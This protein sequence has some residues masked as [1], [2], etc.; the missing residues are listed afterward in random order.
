MFHKYG[1]LTSI[2]E[3]AIQSSESVT[4]LLSDNE[5]NARFEKFAAQLKRIAPKSNEF[6]YFVSPLIV[7]A[8]YALINPDGSPKKTRNGEIV[9]ASWEKKGEG[10]RWVC[11]DPSIRPHKN[12]NGDIFPESEIIAAHKQWISKPI[13]L[14]HKNEI[15]SV[16][17]IVLDVY[18]DRVLKR[19]IALCAIDKIAYPELARKIQTRVSDGMS[20]GTAVEKAI[21]A[22]EGCHKV[23]RTADQF[24]QHMRYKTGYGEI[25][26]GLN[27]IEFSCVTKPAESI[28]RIRTVF[29]AAQQ[30]HNELDSKASELNGISNISKIADLEND[31][32]QIASKFLELKES[33]E[34]ESTDDSNVISDTAPYGAS[35]GQ[36][37]PPSDEINQQETQLNLP[38]RYAYNN[39][40]L[41]EE[42]KTLRASFEHKLSNIEKTL[43][44]KNEELTMATDKNNTKTAY[45]LG[46]GEGNEPTPGKPRYP[47]DPLNE[48]ARMEDKQMVGQKPFPEVGS[49]DGLHPSP[50]SV[51]EKD[52]LKRKEMIQRAEV[53]ER[54]MRRNA[55]LAQ[56][57]STLEHKKSYWLGTEEPTPGKA[58]YPVDPLNVQVREKEDKQMVGQSPFPDVGPVDGLHP[59]PASVAEKDELKRKEMLNR[60]SLK[61]RFVRTANADGTENLGTSGWHVYSK[62][63]SGEKLVFTASVDEISGGRADALFDVIATKEFGSKMLEKIRAVGIQKAASVYKQAQALTGPGAAPGA[64]PDATGAGAMPAMPEAMPPANDNAE[65]AAEDEGGKG[66]PK[67]TAMKLAEKNRDVASDLLEAIRTLT[68]EQTQMGEMEEG[69]NALPKA[70]ASALLPL[71]KTRVELNSQL[72]S[73]MKKSLAELNEHNEELN[74]ITQILDS[75]TVADKDYTNTVVEDA[76]GDAKSAIADGFALMR[77]YMKYARGTAGLLK[78]AEDAQ[79]AMSTDENDARDSSDTDEDTETETETK[80]DDNDAE[81]ANNHFSMEDDEMDIAPDADHEHD[82]HDPLAMHE[83]MDM[84]HDEHNEFETPEGEDMDATPDFGHDASDMN[85]VMVD[86]DP[87][88]LPP[89]Q[90]LKVAPASAQGFDLTTKAGRSAYRAKI[91][92]DATGKQDDGKLES[93]ESLKMS[94]TVED[95]DKLA[96]GGFLQS[97]L[98]VKPSDDLGRFETLPEQQKRMLEVARMPPKIRQAAERLDTLISQGKVAVADLDT[99]IAQGLDS[100]VVKYW[101]QYWGEAGKEGAEFGKLLT[102]ETMKAKAEEENKAFRVKLARA[103]ELSYDM[104]RRGLLADDRAAIGSHVD[105]VM[106]WNDEG[107]ESM[108]RVIARHAPLSIR[109]EAS[110]PQVGL[111]GS[112]DVQSQARELDFQGELDRAFAN[113][114]Y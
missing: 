46:G 94:P 19:A 113:R 66:D 7:S 45:W 114:K 38:E 76:L 77:A 42:L 91:A 58:Q 70:A 41:V 40:A 103:Y 35:S 93:A 33:M 98:D 14:D 78:R 105:E 100:E 31:L 27:P 63:E 101:R 10:I 53:E 6:L 67:E 90:K 102:T 87:S 39:L 5:I 59:S 17:G 96:D 92:N 3:N 56:A 12:S 43:Q 44:I 75:G 25:N 23:A 107:F 109:K 57:K 26:V 34:Q 73:G 29:A 48:K 112:G 1:E 60:A 72:L 15:D 80:T 62:D 32:K 51:A 20:M 21:C 54:T 110:I 52:E 37:N 97:T 8:E 88:Q 85:D 106:K 30:L 99:L 74:L 4:A 28:S 69:L 16:R 18:Y 49:V 11:N 95:A 2:A 9:V 86:V 79:S 55:A 47:I 89:G 61:A 13:L 81:D 64:T 36:L 50:E 108:K 22:E 82:G 84:P 83:E 104:V 24:C 65:P 111:I 71:H 68:G